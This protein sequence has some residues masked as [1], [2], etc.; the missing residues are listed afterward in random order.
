MKTTLL[1]LTPIFFINVLFAEIK[2]EDKKNIVEISWN[3]PKHIEV[4]YFVIEKSKNGRYYKEILKVNAPE[5]HNKSIK[6]SEIDANPYNKKT[7]YRIKQVAVNGR[8]YYS[9]TVIVENTGENKETNIT[10]AYI[11]SRK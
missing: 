3:T 11:H 2:N 8:E 9:N 1:F 10:H 6:Y 7:F 5:K 4:A